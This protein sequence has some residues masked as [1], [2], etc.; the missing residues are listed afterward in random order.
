VVPRANAI[1]YSLEMRILI[2]KLSS[3][4]DI[5]H[6]LP[7]ATNLKAQFPEAKLHWLTKSAYLPLLAGHAAID[8]LHGWPLSPR[9]IWGL[10]EWEF[11]W[12][13]DMQGL[14]KTSAIGRFLGHGSHLAG[15]A[16]SRERLAAQLWTKHVRGGPVLADGEHIIDRNLRILQLLGIEA[17]LRE[18]PAAF[19]LPVGKRHFQAR[20]TLCFPETRWPSKAWPP[21]HWHRLLRQLP[22]PAA[23]MGQGGSASSDL[24]IPEIILD[25]RGRTSLGELRNYLPF[26]KLAVGPDS[27]LLHVAAAYGVPTV[28]LYGPT[29]PLRTG[30]QSGRALS[31]E[32]SCVPCHKRACP[33]TGD[34]NH[35]CMRR[36][37]PETVLQELS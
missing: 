34:S 13:L 4:G 16:P 26:A 33:L 37:T 9:Q 25:L 6:C 10:R 29:S 15:V 35:L 30:P 32:L 23:V 11:D 3:L 24:E 27:G 31:L 2:L 5:V 17:N 21:H 8:H 19:G 1:S 36:L 7:V 18:A 20:D 14:L 12:V 22:D 28:G